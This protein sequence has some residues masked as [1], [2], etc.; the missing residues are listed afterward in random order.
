[1]GK[2]QILAAAGLM[3][4]LGGTAAAA[5]VAVYTPPLTA[6]KEED[7][8]YPRVIRLAH[9]GKNNGALLATF[10][11]KG[12]KTKAT[13]PIYRSD[14]NG[15]TWSKQPLGV[16]RDDGGR[17]ID[18]PGLFELPKAMGDL[19][20]GALL[21]AGTVWNHGDFTQQ[22]MRVYAST[23]G[24]RHW[25]YR[26]SCATEKN[27]PNKMG[28]GIWEPAFAVAADG[29]LVCYFSDER[30]SVDG[31]NQVLAHVRSTDGGKT[32]SKEVWDVATKDNVSR[33]GMTTV[34]RLPDTRYA[35]VYEVCRKDLDPDTA[36]SVRFKTSPDGL[37][38][39]PAN[40]MGTLIA[41]ADGKHLLHTPMIAWSSYG[42]PQG[43]L[44]VTGQR[45]V[46]GPEGKL[47]VEKE[48]GRVVFVNTK[49]GQGPWTL[50][51]S[52]VIVDPTGGYAKSETACPGYSS[53]VLPDVSGP[54]FQVMA[55]VAISNG[56]CRVAIGRGQL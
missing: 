38:W 51:A 47:K 21:A 26:S 31:Y 33:P 18:A 44:I 8:S 19:P 24:G 16:V 12:A 2:H 48:S 10:F 39:N 41:A 17:D 49:L 1:M 34:I 20:E 36:C 54:G 35:M 4:L 14:D 32:W 30:P 42:G 43:T 11:H 5:E 6:D 50:H 55:G 52:P 25:T 29:S 56:K 3:A 27:M 28:L 23:D 13:L 40:N 9:A 45:V 53:P 37:N 46:T 7:A 15:K 22:D